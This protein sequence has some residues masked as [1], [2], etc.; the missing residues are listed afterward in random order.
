MVITKTASAYRRTSEGTRALQSERS[1]P[2]QWYRTILALVEAQD[3]TRTSCISDSFEAH[4]QKQVFIWID[5]L[6]TLGFI[7]RTDPRPTR[8][9]AEATQDAISLDVPMLSRQAA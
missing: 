8:P 6:E 9:F 2:Q 4:P 7:E 1:V 5:E 3:E